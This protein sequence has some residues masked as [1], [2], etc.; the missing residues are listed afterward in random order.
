MEY[1]Y[2]HIIAHGQNLIRRQPD[3]AFVPRDDA[4]CCYMK[5]LKWCETNAPQEFNWDANP[6]IEGDDNG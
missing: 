5:Y 2:E 4:N 3:G 1:T 6:P